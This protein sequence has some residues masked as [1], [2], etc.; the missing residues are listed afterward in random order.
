MSRRDPVEVVIQTWGV[1]E[2]ERQRHPPPVFAVT[3]ADTLVHHICAHYQDLA[4]Y[5]LFLS[6]H[7]SRQDAELLVDQATRLY[8]L[9]PHALGCS[10]KSRAVTIRATPPALKQHPCDAWVTELLG[11]AVAVAAPLEA[12]P[13]PGYWLSSKRIR[14]RPL[15][16][17][18]FVL[19]HLSQSEIGGMMI[20][21]QPYIGLLCG[22]TPNR[23]FEVD[24]PNALADIPIPIAAPNPA[25]NIL[26]VG[27][28]FR[29]CLPAVRARFP[30]AYITCI[31]GVHDRDLRYARRVAVLRMEPGEGMVAYMQAYKYYV[32]IDV[33]PSQRVPIERTRA[34][35]YVRSPDHEL[36]KG[37][38]VTEIDRE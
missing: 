5:T 38:I 18:T 4:A 7:H 25:P 14:S 11:V 23:V 37:W 1:K 19:R 30:D 6:S 2:K 17:W 10:D 33:N 8:D 31:S 3:Y 16:E 28:A 35:F 21:V 15:T 36:P 20:L 9:H 34:E 13:G 29:Q 27:H 32:I 24:L 12:C 22:L 26:I